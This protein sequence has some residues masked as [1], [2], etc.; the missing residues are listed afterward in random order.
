VGAA[1]TKYKQGTPT[2]SPTHTPTLH[3]HIR[4]CVTPLVLVRMDSPSSDCLPPRFSDPPHQPPPLLLVAA[5]QATQHPHQPGLTP[6]PLPSTC[7][8]FL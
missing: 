2:H 8:S 7:P 6:P 4:L 1:V 3:T 5:Q